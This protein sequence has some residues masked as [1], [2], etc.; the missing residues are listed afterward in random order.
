MTQAES[1]DI[2]I[3]RLGEG[4]SA[5]FAIGALPRAGRL[6]FSKV[7]VHAT[8]LTVTGQDGTTE[9]LGSDAEPLA[10]AVIQQLLSDEGLVF[11]ELD[12]DSGEPVATERMKG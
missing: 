11:A 9:E 6:P 5:Q 8:H 1:P 7:E 2:A 3:V 4:D 12:E 10:P